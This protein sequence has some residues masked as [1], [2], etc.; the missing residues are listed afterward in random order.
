MT[1]VLAMHATSIESLQA[2]FEEIS[3]A[4]ASNLSFASEWKF[5]HKQ[6]SELGID[7]VS[8]GSLEDFFLSQA[9]IGLT[10]DP[11]RNLA[12]VAINHDALGKP[13]AWFYPTY[14]G[15]SFLA[16]LS[17]LVAKI[18]S[19]VIRSNDDFRSY[20]PDKSPEHSYTSV[21]ANVRGPV[22]GAY[23]ICHFANDTTLFSDNS[24]TVESMRNDELEAIEM[25]LKCTLGTAWSGPFK[26]M[27]Q[28]KSVVRRL[29]RVLLPQLSALSNNAHFVARLTA[30]LSHDDDALTCAS[31][32]SVVDGE[33][34]LHEAKTKNRVDLMERLNITQDNVQTAEVLKV[35]EVDATED[36]SHPCHVWSGEILDDEQ[37]P[38]TSSEPELSSL[39]HQIRNMGSL[40]W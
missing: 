4:N 5:F 20:G 14:H 28:R 27:M 33:H 26:D 38:A 24:V 9:K 10:L 40:S 34:G 8:T 18:T 11:Q 23:A 19:S 6:L 39:S 30:A 32:T 12:V 17:G 36:S 37:N 2:K 3:Q 29:L 21:D 22:S 35:V 15:Y 25:T 31:E 1:N 7:Q 16:C 13:T